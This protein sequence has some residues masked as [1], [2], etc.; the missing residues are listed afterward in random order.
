[1]S[2]SCLEVELSCHSHPPLPSHPLQYITYISLDTNT[3]AVKLYPMHLFSLFSLYVSFC[4]IINLWGSAIVFEAKVS[5]GILWLADT[6][7]TN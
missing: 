5:I 1:M 2:L 3:Y 7:E 4:I 6:L